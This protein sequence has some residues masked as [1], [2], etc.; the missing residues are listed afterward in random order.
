MWANR[1]RVCTGTGKP[2]GDRNTESGNRLEWPKDPRTDA[3]AAGS[4]VPL[5]Q[6][7][8]T[9]TMREKGRYPP[10]IRLPGGTGA[11][12]RYRGRL[13]ADSGRK[14]ALLSYFRTRLS[15]RHR[16][17][18]AKRRVGT[19]KPAGDRNIESGN[20]L[21]WPKPARTDAPAAGSC[22]RFSIWVAQGY[23]GERGPATST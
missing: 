11:N 5:P 16:P 23:V 3:S 22:G 7:N 19:G 14:G 10:R 17:L 8:G 15:W 9:G 13:C 21:E 20:R 6:P 2:A 18:Y 12:E 4:W 1:N